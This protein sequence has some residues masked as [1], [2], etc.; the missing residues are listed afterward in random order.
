MRQPRILV[1][2]NTFILSFL[3]RLAKLRLLIRT[4]FRRDQQYKKESCMSRG[5]NRLEFPEFLSKVKTE[6]K[7]HL[8]ITNGKITSWNKNE[9]S[10]FQEVTHEPD[11]KLCRPTI[12]CQDVS[13]PRCLSMKNRSKT[14]ICAVC[15]SM[16]WIPPSTVLR[17]VLPDSLLLDKVPYMNL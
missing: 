4:R 3:S 12:S 1:R 2:A 7:D 11:L 10:T 14:F 6:L 17:T 9:Q 16:K 8:M 13:F 15:Y 5:K